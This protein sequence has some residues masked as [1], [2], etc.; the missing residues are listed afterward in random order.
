MR[1]TNKKKVENIELKN[2]AFMENSMKKRINSLQI[3]R[4]FAFVGILAS[5]CNFGQFGAWGVS[6][7]LVLSGF[8]M[9]YSYED[10]KI[11]NR[12]SFAFN[13]IRKLYLLYVLAFLCYVPFELSILFHDFSSIGLLSFIAKCVANLL[14]IQSWIP[15]SDYYFSF[16]GVSWY[17][18]TISFCYFLFP[19]IKNKFINLS[20]KKSVIGILTVFLIQFSISYLVCALNFN[21]PNLPDLTTWLT[22]ISPLYRLGDF[23]I[24]CFLGKIFISR[25]NILKKSIATA[26]EILAIVLVITTYYFSVNNILNFGNIAFSKCLIYLP[27]TVLLVFLFACNQGKISSILNN[28]IIIYIGN[29]SQSGF[30]IHQVVIRYFDTLFS[31]VLDIQIPKGL[32]FVICLLLT[33]AASELYMHLYRKIK[34]GRELKR[35]KSTRKI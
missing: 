35:T 31:K 14:L 10:R 28:R 7:F 18:S 12:K 6:I 15:S 21:N 26:L 1:T 9:V 11:E 33:I 20:V 34:N 25:K 17:L 19:Y 29:I 16:N 23:I 3:L 13:K 32:K 30:L 5:H 22:Y 8:L 24:G 27:T 2:N 4:A